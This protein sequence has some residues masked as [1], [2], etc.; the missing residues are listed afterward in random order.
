VDK[1]GIFKKFK[2]H[3]ERDKLLAH[4]VNFKIYYTAKY[5]VIEE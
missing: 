1:N 3:P 2:T 5:D 4:L